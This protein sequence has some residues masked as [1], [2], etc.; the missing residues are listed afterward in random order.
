[1]GDDS[2]EFLAALAEQVAEHLHHSLPVRHDP[3]QVRRKVDVNLMP[4]PAAAEAVAGLGHQEGHVRRFG[5]DRQR[6]RLNAG[7]VEQVA[8]QHVHPVHL[9]VDD[10]EEL[11]HLGGVQRGGGVQQGG[12][13]A[14]DRG[15]RG[16][17]LVAHHRQELG[18]QPLNLLQR[19]QVLQGD[20]EGLDLPVLRADGRGVEQ[21]GDAAAVGD[22]EDDLLGAHRLPGAQQLRHRQLHEGEFPPVAPPAGQSLKEL[23]RRLCR[24]PQ[25]VDDP[26]RL[27]IE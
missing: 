21:R 23:F 20:D 1:M 27:Q 10:P 19:G 9:G 2:G 12:D 11:P 24:L 7:Y 5:R 25:A 4:A 6:A 18:P 15:Q 8:Y 17:Q 16:A 14:L 26:L 13:G 3:G 22:P